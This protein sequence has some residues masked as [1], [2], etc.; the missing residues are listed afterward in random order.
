MVWRNLIDISFDQMGKESNWIALQVG[1]D[2]RLLK[3]VTSKPIDFNKKTAKIT[4]ASLPLFCNRIW[5]RK[6]NNR[7]GNSKNARAG[8]GV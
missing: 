5:F 1:K 6:R 8:S 3:F 7:H 4:D 2:R